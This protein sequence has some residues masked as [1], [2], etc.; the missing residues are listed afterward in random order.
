MNRAWPA[1]FPIALLPL[2]FHWMPLWRRNGIWFGVT[3]APGYTDGPEARSVLHRFRIAIWLLALAAVTVTALGAPAD[4]PWAFPAAMTLELAGALTA[5]AH[6]RRRTL[7]H[8]VSPSPVRSASLTVAP[9]GLPGG[10]AAVLVPFA[11][12][13]AT[14]LYL[15][16]NWSRIAE[17]FPV[18]WGID[19]SPDRWSGRTWQGVY[20]PLLLGAAHCGLML[21]IGLGILRFSPRGRVAANAA[22]SAQFRRAILQF[23]VAAVW[24]MALLLAAVSLAPVLGESPLGNW[25][26]ILIALGL[27][28]LAIP[29]VWRLIRIGR[30]TGGGGD[31]TPDQCWKLGIFYFNPA[32]AA[33]FV[34]KRFGIGYTINFGNRTTWL[35][36]G[37]TLLFSLVPVLLRYL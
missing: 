32:D 12:L 5:F 34:E 37:L 2:I 20:T 33:I 23:L 26:P 17:R 16:L 6:A 21:L 4:F 10:F 14:A 22:A 11:I 15:S 35:F 27:L 29:F 7:P 31:G 18:H 19:G 13:G 1:I 28:A 36:G 30:T 9:E 8:A 3:V 24:G 25:P